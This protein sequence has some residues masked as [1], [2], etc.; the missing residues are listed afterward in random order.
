MDSRPPVDPPDRFYRRRL[1]H[2]QPAAG[3]IFLTWRLHGSLPAAALARLKEEREALARRPD[4]PDETARERALRESKGLFR[5]TDDLLGHE[6]AGPRWLADEAIA[7]LMVDALFFHDG[8]LYTLIAF[9]VMPN[10]VHV[11]LAPLDRR[12]VDPAY[13]SLEHTAPVPL[14]RIT[15]ALKGYVANQANRILGRTGL[16]FWQDES[17][18]HWVRGD[19][20]MHRIV[21]YIEGDPVKRGLAGTPEE[22]RWSSAWERLHGRLCDGLGD[23]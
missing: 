7:R 22:W 2:W 23:D 9:V 12:L 20:E 5:L 1:P 17:Y 14:Q 15:R 19:A 4:R 10:H 11:L 13:E 21:T 6:T 3:M 16:P 8:R 18:D